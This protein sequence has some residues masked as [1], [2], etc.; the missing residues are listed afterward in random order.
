M[1]RPSA[2]PLRRP[3]WPPY[4]HR[5][6]VCNVQARCRVRISLR[7]LLHAVLRLLSL[8]RPHPWGG[9]ASPRP[10]AAR[11]PDAET[12]G[13]RAVG[14]FRCGWIPV[15]RGGAPRRNPIAPPPGERSGVATSPRR[16]AWIRIAAPRRRR[17]ATGTLPRTKT[18][19][20]SKFLGV[21]R[22]IL[23]GRSKVIIILVDIRIKYQ[24]K[25]N[26]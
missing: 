10:P 2:G 19:W 24:D 23:L 25:T 14:I 1:V 6:P 26:I 7:A 8:V 11:P 18:A 20:C 13:C 21:T 16:H 17:G 5:F 12:T 22:Q 15:T 3:A 9:T 4:S